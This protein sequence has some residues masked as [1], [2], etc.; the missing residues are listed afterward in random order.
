MDSDN[1]KPRLEAVLFASDS[2]LKIER[3]VAIFAVERDLLRRTLQQLQADYARDGRGVVLQEIAGGFQLRTR[4]EYAQWVTQLNRSRQTRL[5]KAATETLAII[6]Y[7]QPVTRV[8]IEYLRGV[9]SGGIVRLLMEKQLIKIV[10]KKDVPGRPLLYGSSRYF[11]EYFGLNDLSGL[12]NLK[13][14][15]DPADAAVSLEMDFD[16]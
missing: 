15:A 4:A 3:L 16:K 8:E 6:A 12:P 13:E 5:S 7:R 11:L 14:F 1:L 9:D 2:P 10:G